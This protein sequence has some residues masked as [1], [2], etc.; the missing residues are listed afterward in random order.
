MELQSRKG[1]GKVRPTLQVK[2]GESS[3]ISPTLVP[4][5]EATE[6]HQSSGERIGR[7]FAAALK[8]HYLYR[9]STYSVERMAPRRQDIGF[10]QGASK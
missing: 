3:M 2:D 5:K 10:T 6:A 1:T 8:Y 9:F 7:S 4:N